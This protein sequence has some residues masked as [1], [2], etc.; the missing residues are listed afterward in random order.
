MTLWTN[1]YRQGSFRSVK[2]FTDGHEFSGGRR[3]QNHEFPQRDNS[4]SEDLG[5]K[6][7]RFTIDLFVLGDAYFDD[8][9][10]L[11]DAL[12]KQ[13]SGELVHPYLGRKL[14]QVGSFTIRET[15]EERR[16]ARFTV[17]FSEAG[18]SLF[19]ESVEDEV[20]KTLDNS[21]GVI[22][23]SKGFFE[24]LYDVLNQPARIVNAASDLI[25]DAS[26]SIEDSV[27]KFTQ[28]VSNLTFA[29]RNL[30]ADA[31]DLARNKTLL[32]DRMAEV[33][34]LLVSEFEDDEDTSQKI[35]GDVALFG[36]DIDPVVGET[37]TANR[38]QQNQD[39]IINMIK[40]MSLAN[41]AKSA[42]KVAFAN[43]E[44]ALEVR[45]NIFDGL[46]AQLNLE[47]GDDLFQS[48]KNLQASLTETIPTAVVG[49]T[50][51]FTPRKTL[52]TLVIS[53]RLFKNL[54]KEQEI[55]DQNNIRHPGFVTGNV[56]LEVS[57]A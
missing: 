44:T 21:D 9:D 15:K 12:E 1:R 31:A 57:S 45:G 56:E 40:Q 49:E 50:I 51:T 8:R 47:I 3:F 53:Q 11:I 6:I 55:I 43:I 34:G 10:A 38:E 29:I 7:R 19:P 17:E 28:P 42:V 24:T 54:E 16:I 27:K 13:G 48:I 30:K 14:V 26:D 41:Q 18:K 2:F 23:D 4:R 36:D 22:D 25:S 5:R 46:D 37:P 33:L 32:A 39:A 35:L 20:Q 52:P